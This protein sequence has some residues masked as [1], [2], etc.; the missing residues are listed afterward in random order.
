MGS[1][2]SDAKY[3]PNGLTDPSHFDMTEMQVDDRTQRSP[4]SEVFWPS[5][6]DGGL[7]TSGAIQLE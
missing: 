6:G 2:K 1:A 5:T 3:P 4:G 7:H